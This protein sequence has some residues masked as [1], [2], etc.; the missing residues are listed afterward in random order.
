ME[1]QTLINEQPYH[2][3]KINKYILYISILIFIL[4]ISLFI[5]VFIFISQ[6]KQNN[7]SMY[8][9]KIEA[10]VDYICKNYINCNNIV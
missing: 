2:K 9:P 3:S 1:C 4:N 6:L 8:I 5:C 7:I 10:I